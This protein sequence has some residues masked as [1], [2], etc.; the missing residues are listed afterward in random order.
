[1]HQD[2][3]TR[4]EAVDRYRNLLPGAQ[5]KVFVDGQLNSETEGGYGFCTVLFPYPTASIEVEVTYEGV[6]KK[7]K[8]A[9]GVDSFPVSF[10]NAQAPNPVGA[11]SSIPEEMV[12][13]IGVALILLSI[14]LAF[15]VPD[16]SQFQWRVFGGVLSVG[17]AAFGLGLSGM[18]HVRV[19]FERRLIISAVGA[20][21][22]FVL[23]YFF[24]PAQ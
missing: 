22:I 14:L 7:E 17:L 23:V 21:A 9:L 8:I 2:W 18:L 4:V 16:P 19:E 10:E 6:T 24:A 13:G 20:L 11:N 5:F 3:V 1:M 15:L 12:F